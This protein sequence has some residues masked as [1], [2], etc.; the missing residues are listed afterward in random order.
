MTDALLAHERMGRAA[1]RDRVR[2]GAGGKSASPRRR[3]RLRAY[4]H[5]LSGGMRQ[6]VAIAIA[7]PAPA[8]RPSSPDEPTTALDVT[9]QGQ[10]LAL[11]PAA[12]PRARDGARLDHARPRGRRRHR[13]SDRRDVCRPHRGGGRRRRGSRCAGPIPTARGLVASVPVP[14]RRERAAADPGPDALAARTSAGLRLRPRAAP[15]RRRRAGSGQTS[16]ASPPTGRCAA[17]FRS[18]SPCDEAAGRSSRRT[19]S[20]KVFGESRDRRRNGA[21]PVR[22]RA[23]R[24]ARCEPS[25]AFFSGSW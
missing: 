18:W 6:R 12:L 22:P 19:T 16:R 8:R 13:R 2:E 25:T 24:P 17:I 23:P 1:A 5:Q 21:R 9:I 11:V 20:S 15:R 14:G 4:P 10:I 7:P 3:E